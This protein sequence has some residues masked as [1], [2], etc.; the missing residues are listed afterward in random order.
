MSSTPRK[1][2]YREKSLTRDD[3][4]CG[5]DSWDDV[6]DD[7]LRQRPSNTLDVEFSSATGRLIK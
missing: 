4:V 6:L 3:G 2:W 5:S 1:G 7:S